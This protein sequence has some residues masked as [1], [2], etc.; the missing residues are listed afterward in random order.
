MS[1][2]PS[3]D[4]LPTILARLD[5]AYDFSAWH[6]QRQTPPEYIAISAILVQH[7]NWRNV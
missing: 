1:R 4:L 2:P 5:A 7:T 3:T 6:W